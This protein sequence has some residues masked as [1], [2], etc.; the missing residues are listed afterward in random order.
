MRR[1]TP[2]RARLLA[3]LLLQ[4]CAC[5]FAE[6]TAPVTATPPAAPASPSDSMHMHHESPPPSTD[7]PQDHAHAA[8]DSMGGMGEHGAGSSD[9]SSHASMDMSSMGTMPMFFAVTHFSGALLFSWTD[10][11]TPRGYAL[12]AFALV[13]GCI[14]REWLSVKRMEVESAIQE[15]AALHSSAGSVFDATDSHVHLES[16]RRCCGLLSAPMFS[17][18][19][20]G[21][22]MLVG[23]CLMLVV[24]S[25]DTILFSLI[26]TASVAAHYY[27]QHWR[28]AARRASN[29]SRSNNRAAEFERQHIRTHGQSGV[30]LGVGGGSLED[31]DSHADGVTHASG[32][33]PSINFSHHAALG[34]S[35]ALAK[36]PNPSSRSP[37]AG[38]LLTDLRSSPSSSRGASGGKQAAALHMNVTRDC[39]DA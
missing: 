10:L 8:D 7:A 18:L 25:Y 26:L 32:A 36:S 1:V 28:P 4:L 38:L 30:R 21:F 5:V 20:Y 14:L 12:F 29:Q 6:A 9:T 17:S 31:D 34:L 19:L 2:L 35:K 15:L 33:L 11:S 3:I 27:F 37:G 23:Y 13:L 24:M 39:C 22:N 16:H